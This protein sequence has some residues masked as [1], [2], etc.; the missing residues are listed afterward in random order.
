MPLPRVTGLLSIYLKTGHRVKS[1]GGFLVSATAHS[2]FKLLIPRQASLE[3]QTPSRSK[4]MLLKLVRPR[5]PPAPPCGR[6]SYA[7]QPPPVLKLRRTFGAGAHRYVIQG[8]IGHRRMQQ[9]VL[10]VLQPG[11]S[12][13]LQRRQL[14]LESCGVHY[15]RSEHH[16]RKGA[17]D[18]HGLRFLHGQFGL[19]G[20]I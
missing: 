4:M 7:R 18:G 9:C 15:L 13:W 10:N 14:R 6:A 3:W 19:I 12:V 1:S 11:D 17:G 2:K 20:H 8:R 5:P 16:G